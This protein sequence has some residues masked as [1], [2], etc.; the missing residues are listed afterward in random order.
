MLLSDRRSNRGY[1]I[2]VL[3]LI[4]LGCGARVLFL[5]G[6]SLW[7]D[8]ANSVL[9]IKGSAA[10]CIN[11]AK[12]D[13]HPPLYYLLLHFWSSLGRDE[14]TLRL[15]SVLTNVLTGFVLFG[16]ARSMFNSRIALLALLLFTIS[17]FQIR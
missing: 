12:T 13:L 16:L 11:H 9:F 14:F 15:F 3:V 17:P 4:L 2:A 6:P 7:L 1:L 8:E 5:S 10:D